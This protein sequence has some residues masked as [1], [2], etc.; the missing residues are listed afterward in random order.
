MH[1]FNWWRKL[2]RFDIIHSGDATRYTPTHTWQRAKYTIV[3]TPRPSVSPIN[4]TK[5]WPPPSAP[6]R[7]IRKWKASSRRP[8]KT[9]SSNRTDT[10]RDGMPCREY[11]TRR[12]K[13]SEM[14]HATQGDRREIWVG[15]IRRS[16][17]P[18]E[19]VFRQFRIVAALL[20]RQQLRI[21]DLNCPNFTVRCLRY[22][23]I[24][25]EGE[26]VSMIPR[27]A[28]VGLA[29]R[30]R[31]ILSS[32]VIFIVSVGMVGRIIVRTVRNQYS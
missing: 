22:T 28:A 26:E 30:S 20:L 19:V 25:W 14:L 3:K 12:G 10:A 27:G 13:C 5:S 18:C 2:N 11:L 17:R 1:Y 9:H 7:G 16:H 23:K 24:D 31:L 6:P 29:I 8:I 4:N 21:M 32:T 15:V